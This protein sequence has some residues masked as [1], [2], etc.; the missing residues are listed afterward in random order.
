VHGSNEERSR[1]PCGERVATWTRCNLEVQGFELSAEHSR[2]LRWAVRLPTA[3][4]LALVV[5]G[6]AL[7]SAVIILAL[8]PI[9]AVAGWT[10]RHPFDA[11]WNHGL[12]RAFGAPALP[13]NP[14]RRRH[15]FKLATVWLLGVDVLLAVGETTAALV[16]AAPMLAVCGV[17]TA[18]NFCVP[19]TLLALW[20]RRGSAAAAT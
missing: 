13:P 19:S 4:C 9:G 6:L 2:A 11:I 18:T 8:V 17:V 20:E 14:T 5:I 10:R 7:Q 3:L 12:R 1:T 16:L 15:D